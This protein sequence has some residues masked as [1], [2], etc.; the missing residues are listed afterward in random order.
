MSSC[1][2][3]TNVLVRAIQ[4]DDRQMRS[5]ARDSLKALHHLAVAICVFPQNLIELWSVS[6][7]P[8]YANGLGL[9]LSD[10]E[11]NL[12]R[13][14]A[15]FHVFPETQ[16][17]FSEWKRLIARYEVSGIKVHDARLV[18]AMNVHG[19]RRILTF[20]VDDFKR[21]EGIQILHPQDVLSDQPF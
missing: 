9:S 1:L 21:Y 12:K 6:T 4:K 16:S 19:V 5:C 14:E 3:D 18:A 7:R 17:I 20:D 11:R 10:A 15:L 2:V 8:I 13:C